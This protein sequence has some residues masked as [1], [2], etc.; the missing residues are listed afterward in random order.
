MD[1]VR[2]RFD[3][4]TLLLSAPEA[5]PVRGLPGVTWDPRVRGFR[6]PAHRYTELRAALREHDIFVRDEVPPTSTLSCR[7]QP[8]ELRSYQRAAVDAW[9]AGG[10]RGLV[11]LPTGSGK[12]R[13][14]LAAMRERARSTLCLVPTIA[15]LEQWASV[16]EQAVDAPVG[17]LG[18]RVRRVEAITVATFESALRNMHHLGDRFDLLIVDE[19]HHFGVG[20]RDE[21]LEMSI[22]PAR[23]GLTATAPEDPLQLRRL[24]RLM[25]PI[26]Y[27]R[28][29]S[30]LAGTHL[31]PLTHSRMMVDLSPDERVAYQTRL[32]IYAAFEAWFRRNHPNY[33]WAELASE[34]MKSLPGR[35]AL[36]AWR[37]IRRLLAY[38][39]AKRARLGEL[40]ARHAG[41]RILVFCADNAAAYAIAREHLLMPITC[42]IDRR[43][44][45]CA[46]EAFVAGKLR[47][48]VSARVLNEGIDLPSADVAIVV[49][50]AHGGREHVQRIGRILRP[51][52][53]KQAVLWELVARG[54][55]E[56]IWSRRRNDGVD[57]GAGVRVRNEGPRDRPALPRTG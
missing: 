22:A 29:L 48:L 7:W 17:R 45:A 40:L 26:V 49:S 25:G 5:S 43:E 2:L 39:E 56:V 38:P 20:R 3:R 4:G 51:A 15:L 54:T 24:A 46:F 12:T 42:D 23:L 21:T 1:P 57:P 10:S 11:V 37:E 14:A 35:R 36:Y 32:E 52:E 31:A 50:G 28:A 30:D 53:G 41:S 18:D 34:A 13:V 6:A 9:T 47:G 16:L 44:R 55:L 19:A 27:R 33:R 8:F